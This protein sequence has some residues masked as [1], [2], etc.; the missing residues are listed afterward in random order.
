MEVVEQL[1]AV[2]TPKRLHRGPWKIPNFQIS[3]PHISNTS[4]S[5]GTAGHPVKRDRGVGLG[6]DQFACTCKKKQFHMI[7]KARPHH[8]CSCV[9]IAIGFTIGKVVEIS[10]LLKNTKKRHCSLPRDPAVHPRD[11]RQNKPERHWGPP[12]G[13]RRA[14]S[15]HKTNGTGVSRGTPAV[16]T[17]EISVVGFAS[18]L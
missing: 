13:P 11:A 16:K 5:S 18:Y 2:C 8:S 14:T 15:D 7:L 17:V 6:H 1:W 4:G 3:K 12:K 10:K 9:H